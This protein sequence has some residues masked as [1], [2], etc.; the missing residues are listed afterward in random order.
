MQTLHFRLKQ[1]LLIMMATLNSLKKNKDMYTE[2][3]NLIQ[4]L[5]S[6]DKRIFN[7]LKRYSDGT[8]VVYVTNYKVS[9]YSR[10]Y[11]YT[12]EGIAKA[13]EDVKEFVNN[14]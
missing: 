12:P 1:P 10:Q 11:S 13:L 14:L 2:L 5:D 8:F 9:G 6:L 3:T 4:Y 7:I